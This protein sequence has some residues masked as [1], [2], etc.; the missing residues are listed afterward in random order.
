MNDP[1]WLLL[2]THIWIWWVKQDR[3]LSPAIARRLEESK[4]TLAISSISMYEAILLIR[5]RRIEIDLL[6]QEWLY[7]ATV[8]AGIEIYPVDVGIATKAAT[9]PLQHGDPLDRIII[10]TALH[11]D[12]LLVSVDSQFPYYEALAGRL[13]SDKD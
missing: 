13:I 10:A 3:Q 2:D 11:Y 12:A 6:L 4:A 8:E 5:R 9:L 1:A 7:A